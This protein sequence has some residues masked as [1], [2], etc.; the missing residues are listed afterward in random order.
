MLN[1]LPLPA[2][3]LDGQARIL[4][5]NS[6]AEELLC[7][8]ALHSNSPCF[9]DF[10]PGDEVASFDTFYS[11][12]QPRSPV[13][14]NTTLC[15][16]ENVTKPV[17][18]NASATREGDRIFLLNRQESWK[19][20]CGEPCRHAAILEAQYENNPGGI[21]LVSTEMKMLSFNREF[22][23][24]WGIPPEIQESRDEEASLQSVLSKLV[25]PE[26][27]RVKVQ[28]LYKNMHKVSTDEVHLTDGRCLFRHTYPI[29]SNGAC[30]GRV[31]YF[32]DIT[33]LKRAQSQV[34]RQLVMQ[35]AILEHVQDGIVACDAGG[36]ISV[37]NRACRNLCGIHGSGRVPETIGEIDSYLQGGSAVDGH[38][39]G[40]LQKVL[41][42]KE[43]NSDEVVFMDPEG[44]NHILRFSGQAMSDGSGKKNGAV[45]SFHDIT[46][47]REAQ[48]RLCFFAY[49]DHLTGLP[50]RRLFHD[51]LEQVLKQAQRSNTLVGVLF[52]DLDNFKTVNDNYGHHTGDKLLCHV[53]SALKECLRGSDILCRWGGDEFVIGLPSSKKQEDV[54]NVAEKIRDMVLRQVSGHEAGLQV[55]LSI[56]IALFPTHGNDPDRLIRDADVAMYI[57]K[58]RGKN[59]CELFPT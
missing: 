51:L 29:Y 37:M 13:I 40:P 31:W 42:E 28:Y 49:H 54:A 21:L 12:I 47:L 23:K 27:F 50:N 48:E 8:P 2:I 4:H 5:G 44:K 52:L 35:D 56:G 55:S 19:A 17:T 45:V 7:C 10:I 59:R 41:G 15:L 25:E 30:L 46:D 3:H 16:D 24:I 14:Y 9:T 34:E 1:D 32:L 58:R 43:L 33:T 39:E 11:T 57:A 36:R 53:V 18:I 20:G 22:V 6:L 38:S 26:K